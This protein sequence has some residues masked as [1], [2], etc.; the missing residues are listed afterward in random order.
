MLQIH[1]LNTPNK[2]IL[3][4]LTKHKNLLC[5]RDGNIKCLSYTLI[6]LYQTKYQK[7][8][9]AARFCSITF[10]RQLLYVILVTI[11]VNMDKC[12]QLYLYCLSNLLK[13]ILIALK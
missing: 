13:K 1:Y 8:T 7:K 5:F 3:T 9:F 11:Y 4:T 6:P 10:F 12:L 2:A